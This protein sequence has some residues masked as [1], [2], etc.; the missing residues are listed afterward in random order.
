MNT[1]V[2]LEARVDVPEL[3]DTTRLTPEE[4]D[5][6]LGF[7]ESANRRLGGYALVFGYLERWLERRPADGPLTILDIGTGGGDLP[8]ALARW[9][10][11]RG[12]RL[13]VVGLDADPSIAA[14]ARRR[15]AGEPEVEIVESDLAAFARGGRTFDF[16]IA[17]LLLHHL[18]EPQL[19]SALQAFDRLARRGVVISDLRRCAAGYLAVSL[20]TAVFGGRVTRHDGPV[21]VRRA[22]REPELEALARRAGL[23]Y[24]LARRHS[25]FRLALA[26]EK[27]L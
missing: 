10:R 4:L 3:M 1:F 18:P 26:G 15:V 25:F 24:L 16:V 7:L 19:V 11:A 2:D 27:E 17:S 6:T 13:S 23:P 8:A 22:F 5:E 12:V 9:G 20:L 14:W 21:S